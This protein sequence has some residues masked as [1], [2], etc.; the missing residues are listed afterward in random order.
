[1]PEAEVK[2]TFVARQ[3][4]LDD[5]LSI[6]A[7]QSQGAGVQHVVL[8]APRG[9]GKTT[10]LLMV[11]FG[12]AD[13][14]LDAQWQAVRFPEESYAITDLADFWLE[15]L[16]HLSIAIEQPRLDQIADELL[17]KYG[18]KQDLEEAA[19]AQLRRWSRENGK[20]LLLLVDN[21]DQIIEQIRDERDEAALR[22]VL[23]ND[24]TFMLIGAA[25]AHFREIS[26]YESP[27]YNFFQVFHLEELEFEQI[28]ELLRQRAAADNISD[29][30][31]VL[32][33][34][35]VKLK[36]L[37][38]FTGGNPR[39]ILMLY[40]VVSQSQVGQVR[41][42]LE[43]LLDEVTPYYKAKID[44]LPAQ[45]RKILDHIA[46]ISAQTNEGLTPGEIG[47]AT[48]ISAQAASTQLKRLA[49][50]GYVRAA[51]L[52]GRNSYYALSEP[53]Y[54]I[55]HQMRF[56]RGPQKRVGWLV[57]FL[58]QWYSD[59]E[60]PLESARLFSVF[61]DLLR[62]GEK[63]LALSNLEHQRYLILAMIES[64]VR[65][66][67]LRT[68]IMGYAR[69]DENNIIKNEVYPLC[70]VENL[71]FV[72]L[73]LLNSAGC[74]SRK[75]LDE[76]IEINPRFKVQSEIVTKY[77]TIQIQA[78]KLLKAGD[79]QKCESL[80]QSLFDYDIYAVTDRSMADDMVFRSEK[81]LGIALSEQGKYR[82]AKTLLQNAVT[83]RPYDNLVWSYLL[84]GVVHL[85][86]F[87]EILSV[88]EK[89][90]ENTHLIAEELLKRDLRIHIHTIRMYAFINIG[91]SEN[92][93]SSF[94]D[95]VE[96]KSEKESWILIVMDGLEQISLQ[97]HARRVREV[98]AETQT[99]EIFFPL[100]RAL[101]YLFTGDEA[102]IEKLSPEMRPL[103]VEIVDK[104]RLS[105]AGAAQ[106]G[107]PKRKSK[108][109]PRNR[110]RKRLK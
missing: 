60:K 19:L 83:K 46:R 33:A 78:E 54:A 43:K 2:A 108:T 53:L 89:F 14:G 47:K 56:G 73:T 13:R 109:P 76:L 10:L 9:M 85:D 16:R 59:E 17:D 39:L 57:N 37:R 87:S 31:E 88:S 84:D 80:I 24:G 40:R 15:T 66:E 44:S 32:R 29:Y 75:E 105:V 41:E 62:R 110:T 34:N 1:M 70:K 20:R 52:R 99:E 96:F 102:F 92:A 71:D 104:L 107:A 42:G 100:A 38:Y 27:L 50:L 95:A 74:L 23:M 7:G 58:K 77:I 5:L 106:S 12:L 97:G 94:R 91:D 103:V 21:F 93:L 8:I 49:D 35:A 67:A 48:R 90:Y 45:Q 65:A 3:P 36:V 51:N 68:L 11:Q 72:S 82:Q 64:D 63:A 25:P 79:F 55:W 81:S 4:L 28:L 69:I 26:H 6:I 22:N 98:I 86:K 18:R 101:D 30:E 61:E